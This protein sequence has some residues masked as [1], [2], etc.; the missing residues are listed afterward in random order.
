MRKQLLYI[1]LAAL[2]L[3]PATPALALDKDALADSITLFANRYASVGKVSVH[4]VTVR[5]R[6]VSVFANKNLS[7]IPFTPTTVRELRQKVSRI[8]L[9]NTKGEVSIYTDGYELSELISRQY[10]PAQ[11]KRKGYTLPAMPAV[12]RNM[13]APYTTDKGLQ[14][15]HLAVYGSHGVYY[16]QTR[17][18][19]LWQ[20][21]RLLTTVEDL[22]T[23]SYTMPFLVPMLENAGAVVF[24]PKERDTQLAEIIMDDSQL[25]LP[26]VWKTQSDT[27][28]ATP[29]Q[30][31]LEG[32]NPFKAGHYVQAKGQTNRQKT[33]TITYAPAITDEGEYAVYV[34]YKSLSNS[35]QNAE[36]TVVHKGTS[37][38]FNVNQR[39]GGSTWIYLGTFAFGTDR[40]ANYVSLNNYGKNNE[41]ITSDAI[42]FGGGMGSVARYSQS[43]A[44]E[45]IASSVLNEADTTIAT[46]TPVFDLSSAKV[47]GYP[48]YME[49]AR[50]WLQYAGI[51]DSVYN[52]SESTN[53][54]ID[55]YSARGR[56][57]NY[58]SGGSAANPTKGGLNIPIHLGL[59]FHTD[60]GTTLNDSTIGTL[61]IYTNCNN[62]KQKRYPTGVSRLAARD[63][64]DYIQTQ[65]VD[66]VRNTF[67]PEWQRRMLYNASYS[68]T[69]L[70]EVPTL[71]LELLSHQNFADM[72]YGLDPRFR[73]VVSRAIYKGML[74]FLHEQYATPYAVQP[75]PVKDFA[76][77]MADNNQVILSWQEQEDTLEPTAKAGYYILY[78]RT[79]NGDW[80]NGRKVNKNTYTM[81]LLPDHRYDFKIAAGNEGGISLPS[82][83]LSAHIS[84][85]NKG[86]VLVING[87]SRV[88]APE[89]F[90]VDSTLA[91]FLPASQSVPYGK[92]IHYIGVQHEFDR[93][94]QWITDDD[95]GF[96]ACYTDLDHESM[97]GNTFDYPVMH[98]KALARMG[99]S[100]VSCSASAIDSIS[101]AFDMV[102]IIMGKQRQTTI[103]TEKQITDFKT[104]SPALQHA[105]RAY[106]ASGG[107]LLLSGAYLST[108]IYKN[109]LATAEDKAFAKEVLHYTHRTY[110]ATRSGQLSL[111]A[112]LGILSATL[113]TEPNDEIIHCEN[114]DGIA[115]V[116]ENATVVARY[117]DSKVSAGIAVS[118]PNKM[119]IFSFPLESVA[120][121]EAL[122]E[123]CIHYLTE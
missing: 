33:Q 118:N 119:L 93:S 103:G 38:R 27:G 76:I 15:K 55:D 44:I 22:Y 12:V 5:N 31:L 62:E 109:P 46:A 11:K 53:D 47:S 19:W 36:Y 49:G 20:R 101:T 88:G 94:L 97:M 8:V 63:Y 56:W 52:F 98:G 72:R 7:C 39:M 75:L 28:W 115:P 110:N 102:D 114:P 78:T 21:A 29:L 40:S 105:V 59:A 89:S 16:Q 120:E 111:Q 9:G 26:A 86:K 90:A 64:A 42:R 6:R 54:Y 79:D 61:L 60:A 37:T 67:A 95:A 30:P 91:G 84:S 104:F 99:Y 24:Q 2:L 121:F 43:N 41:V 50:Y 116:G 13:S 18:C 69:R 71:I 122:Y 112:P 65:I 77:H 57:I 73:F 17:G 106:T 1:L 74:R 48:R 80:D 23:S 58:L 68:E 35:S 14:G 123:E 45:N 51:P 83:I 70:P 107:N 82:E 10:Q 4:R 92:D 108:D 66:D 113:H 96:G 100:Y 34:S 3:L 81:T 85:Q 32:Q 25:A 117:A 87:F